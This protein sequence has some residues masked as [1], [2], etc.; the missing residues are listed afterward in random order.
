MMRILARFTARFASDRS[1]ATAIEYG[2]IMGLMFL[3]ILAG[4]IVLSGNFGQTMQDT[5]EAITTAGGGGGG[6]S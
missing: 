1:G 6:A 4:L 5:S 2:L 3:T